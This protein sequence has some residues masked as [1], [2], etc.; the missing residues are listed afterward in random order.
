MKKLRAER[1]EVKRVQ[2]KDMENEINGAPGAPKD[3]ANEAK[4]RSTPILRR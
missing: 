2:G 3:R 4:V 1:Y